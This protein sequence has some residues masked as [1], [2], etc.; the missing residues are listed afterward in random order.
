MTNSIKVVITNHAYHRALD[1]LG[2]IGSVDEF[3]ESLN[4][5]CSE[6]YHIIA[7]Q[8]LYFA[9]TNIVFSV[10]YDIEKNVYFARTVLKNIYHKLAHEKHVKVA[11]EAMA[12][13]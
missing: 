8:R 5:T 2:F 1:R 12:C 13:L 9:E 11:W 4:K 7:H 10:A 6:G 3:A